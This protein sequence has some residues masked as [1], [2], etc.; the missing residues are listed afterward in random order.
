MA[1]VVDWEQVAKEPSDLSDEELEAALAEDPEDLRSRVQLARRYLFQILDAE[2]QKRRHAHLLWLIEHHPEV[3]CG[4][5]GISAALWPEAYAAGKRAW[6]S[7]SGARP[8]DPIVI[9]HAS[10][11]FSVDDRSIAKDLMARG[12]A[13]EPTVAHWHLC[14]GFQRIVDWFDAHDSDANTRQRLAADAVAEYEQAV[15]LETDPHAHFAIL[16]DLVRAASMAAQ[17]DRAAQVATRIL[18]IA[19]RDSPDLHPRR[20]Y[21]IHYARAAL[22]NAALANN[23]IASACQYLDAAKSVDGNFPMTHL[24]GPDFTLA[25]ALL[26]HGERDAVIEYLDGIEKPWPCHNHFK[27]WRQMIREGQTPSFRLTAGVSP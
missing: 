17:Y 18:A 19:A 16:T 7:V 10:R 14:L 24:L 12:A 15:A 3:D 22:G 11:F 1:D 2:A 4:Y 25:T 5:M 27:Q 9:N 8:N 23:D 21:A 6:L 20:E 13:L 26:A